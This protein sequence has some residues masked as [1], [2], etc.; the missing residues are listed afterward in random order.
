MTYETDSYF[1]GWPP[2]ERNTYYVT[3]TIV[4]VLIT[5]S[6]IDNNSYCDNK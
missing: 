6:F 2:Y 5:C 1:V 4:V 3:T